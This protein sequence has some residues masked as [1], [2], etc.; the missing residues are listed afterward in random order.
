MTEN[1]DFQPLPPEQWQAGLKHLKGSFAERLNVYRVMAHHPALLGAWAALRQ[2]VVVDNM[3]GAEL[4]EIAILR[5]AYHLK[6][7]YERAHHSVRARACGI[8]DET[9][10]AILAGGRV[11]DQRYTVIIKSVDE[12]A[13]EARLSA[14]TA[15]ALAAL[16]GKSGVLDLMAVVGFYTTL[17]YILNS[18]VTPV[19]KDISAELG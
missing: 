19:D 14:P 2:H 11:D 17:A 10:Q 3:L 4:T 9:I 1:T 6:C 13:I 8:S 5:A 18:F 7:E 12:L 16:T 15:G